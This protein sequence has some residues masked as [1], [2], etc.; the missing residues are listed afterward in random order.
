MKLFLIWLLG[1]PLLV[2]S[3]VM[4]QTMTSSYAAVSQC[5]RQIDLHDV[6]PTVLLQG[7]RVSCNG[8]SVH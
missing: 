2:T 5:S 1:V 7:N 8:N 4:A 6:A 3:M